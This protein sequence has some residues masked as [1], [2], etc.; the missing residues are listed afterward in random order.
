[1]NLAVTELQLGD[2]VAARD[3]AER[4]LAIRP[5]DPNARDMLRRLGG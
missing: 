5:D 4:A 3:A 1:M 2:R